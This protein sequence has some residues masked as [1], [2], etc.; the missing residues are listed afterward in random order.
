MAKAKA[1]LN[2]FEKAEEE[3]L[4]HPLN[5]FEAKTGNDLVEDY[6]SSNFHNEHQQIKG[7]LEDLANNQTEADHDDEGSIKARIQKE[8][9]EEN[10]SLIRN[11]QVLKQKEDKDKNPLEKS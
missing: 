6:L 8:E 9:E 4:K 5:K 1:K 11:Y 3:Y 10:V 2:V 7:D